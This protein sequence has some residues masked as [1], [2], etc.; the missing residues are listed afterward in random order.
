VT[1]PKIET[2]A[3]PLEMAKAQAGDGRTLTG[4]ASVFNY[5]IETGEP[6]TTFIRPGAFTKTLKENGS[7]VKML[8]NHGRDSEMPLGP[9][10][11]MKE[12]DKGLYVEGRISDTTLGRDIKELIRDGAMDGMS[13]QFESKQEGW[14]D[15]RTERYIQQVRLYELGPVVFPANV[16]ATATVHSK[17]KHFETQ[18]VDNSQWDGN[19]AMGACD[20]AGC[21]RAICAGERSEGDPD[22]RQHW[23]LPHHKTPSSPPNAAGVRNALA[24]LPQT[25]GLTNASAAEAHLNRHMS[26][27]QAEASAQ[28]DRRTEEAA[29]SALKDRL[30]WEREQEEFE[31]RLKSL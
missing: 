13:I 8:F 5:P 1:K 23:A 27:I 6:F 26:A 15:D 31:R 29:A 25:Q 14:N 20:S 16:A 19:A 3:I 30:T 22:E 4:Y 12:D 18:Q 17:D 7:E 9:I 10:T 21:Y 24:R 2:M 28:V 11:H